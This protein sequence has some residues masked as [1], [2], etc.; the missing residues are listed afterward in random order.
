MSALD[1]INNVQPL[2]G[3]PMVRLP[4][5]V[6]VCRTHE[7]MMGLKLRPSTPSNV[8]SHSFGN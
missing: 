3:I 5:E 2:G 7:D 8:Y 6:A 4:H 1:G